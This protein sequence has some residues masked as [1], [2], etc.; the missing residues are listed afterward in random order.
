LP[1]HLE[2]LNLPFITEIGD[3]TFFSNFIFPKF[4]VHLDLHIYHWDFCFM[5]N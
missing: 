3:F 2:V 1:L 4:R 5:K